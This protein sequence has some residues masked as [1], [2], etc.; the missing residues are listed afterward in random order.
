MGSWYRPTLTVTLTGRSGGA[1]GLFIYAT[2]MM[3]VFP[4]EK[5]WKLSSAPL[6]PDITVTRP[7]SLGNRL[8]N[9]VKTVVIHVKL[10]ISTSNR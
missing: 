10:A 2:L 1:G 4:R 8:W 6:H 5:W 7:V 3:H 9:R